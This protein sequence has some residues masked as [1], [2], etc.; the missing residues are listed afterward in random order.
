MVL[1][2][3]PGIDQNLSMGSSADGYL[4]V[5]DNNAATT[6]HIPDVKQVVLQGGWLAYVE[7][8]KATLDSWIKNTQTNESYS[9]RRE[10][11][12]EWDALQDISTI[13]LVK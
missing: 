2:L 10:I 3:A 12:L 6:V 8:Q 11:Q 5:A 7:G 13:D 9:N 1:R 4:F